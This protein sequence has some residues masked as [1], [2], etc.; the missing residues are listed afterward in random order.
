MKR[1]Q[2]GFAGKDYT[3][4]KPTTCDQHDGSLLGGLDVVKDAITVK[5]NLG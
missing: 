5:E 1:V 2:H 3:P 4:T